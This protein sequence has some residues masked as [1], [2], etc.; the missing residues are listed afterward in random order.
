VAELGH[1]EKARATLV[2]LREVMKQPRWAND[3]G[4]QGFL[5]EA[6]ERIEG[7]PPS[8][9]RPPTPRRGALPWPGPSGQ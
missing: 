9:V 5:C 3:A 4:A 1:K 7:K 6:E 2:R 8:H